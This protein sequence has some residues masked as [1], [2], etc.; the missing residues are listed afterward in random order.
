MNSTDNICCDRWETEFDTSQLNKLIKPHLI[1]LLTD[2]SQRSGNTA[3][4]PVEA[5]DTKSALC[6]VSSSFMQAQT[7]PSTASTAV[8]KSL[9]SGGHVAE[10]P[11]QPNGELGPGQ[12]YVL[13]ISHYVLLQ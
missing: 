10:F 3:L 12:R 7:A 13:L 4:K 6:A 2:G 11:V 1:Y 9:R 8:G 5:W